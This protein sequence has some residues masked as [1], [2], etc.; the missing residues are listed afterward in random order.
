M[1]SPPPDIG[2]ALAGVDPASAVAGIGPVT[3]VAA[4]R[5]PALTLAFDDD[6]ALLRGASAGVRRAWSVPDL[7][8]VE[9]ERPAEDPAAAIP[10]QIHP[11][12]LAEGDLPGAVADP[13]G[14]VVAAFTREGRFDVLAILR[15]D[16]SVVRWV[17]GVRAAAWS[18]DGLRLALGGTWGVL[19]AQAREASP[20]G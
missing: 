1:L 17:R 9:E 13:T 11:A 2:L 14:T 16:R 15:D 7:T 18:P 5:E 19:L 6:G 20:E 10:P 12:A 4:A 3:V 8:V